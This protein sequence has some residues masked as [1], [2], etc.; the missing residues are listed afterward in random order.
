MSQA[1]QLALK[2]VSD[3][4][5]SQLKRKPKDYDVRPVVEEFEAQVP[6]VGDQFT[7][8]LTTIGQFYNSEPEERA[9][10][11]QNLQ[12]YG[13]VIVGMV[14]DGNNKL[15]GGVVPSCGPSLA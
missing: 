1:R 4:P 7:P 5:P 3:V 8:H 2:D 6:H 14:L 12:A 15:K 10:K 9:V 11:W 13:E